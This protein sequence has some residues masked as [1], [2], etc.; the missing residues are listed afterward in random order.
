[1]SIAFNVEQ[2][3]VACTPSRVKTAGDEKQVLHSRL[4]ADHEPASTDDASDAPAEEFQEG[5]YGWVVVLAV[6]LLNA[7]TW[8]MNSSYAV[9]LA[10][11]LRTDAIG[12]ASAIAFAFI[13]AFLVSPFANIC[14]RRRGTRT[15]LLTGV[16]FE[17]VAFVGASFT[18]QM[19]QLLLA[20]GVAFGLGMGFIFVASVGVVPQWFVRRRSF[21]NSLATAGSGFGG[22]TYSL[23]TN[24][25]I[26]HMGLAW[27][28]RTI[29]IVSCV[30]NLA[31]TMMVRDRNRSV[32]AVHAAFDRTLFRRP[33]YYLLMS[34][35]FFS[36]LSYTIIVF[37]L[38]DYAETVGGTAS[39]GSLVG[40][41]FNLSQGIG[42][43][44][45]GLASDR[46]GRI[47]VAGLGTLVA[48]LAALFVWNFA[49]RY[50]GGLVVYSLLGGFAGILWA[51]VAPVTAEVVGIALLPSALS[52]FW[53]VLAFPATFAEVIGLSL[54]T[55]GVGAYLHVQL[56]TGLCYIAAFLSMWLL[57]AW[58]LHQMDDSRQTTPFVSFLLKGKWAFVVER[59]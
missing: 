24:A 33:E 31:S 16:F 7:H 55:A 12:G 32:G 48:G 43:P 49:G 34:W 8:G 56:F 44:L 23:A 10:Y 13:G 47:N 6:F 4:S 20:Q 29:A 17:T 46:V 54:R 28:F 1:M 3:I 39:Q 11:Y 5:G 18:K 21:A 41:L 36:L 22:L 27:A 53:V 35:G 59:V 45:I 26:R 51:T 42:R 30:V 15:A 25:M 2:A 50:Y 40:A 57:R 58:K 19:W 9:F 14:I 37:S 52:V 38:P